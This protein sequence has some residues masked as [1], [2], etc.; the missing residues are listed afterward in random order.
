M[1]RK[2]SPLKLDFE[3]REGQDHPTLALEPRWVTV[4]AS[5]LSLIC[6]RRFVRVY[7]ISIM[8]KASSHFISVRKSLTLELSFGWKRSKF[9]RQKEIPSLTFRPSSWTWSSSDTAL[10]IQRSTSLFFS[11]P[12]SP[13][14]A[15]LGHLCL[16]SW[17]TPFPYSLPEHPSSL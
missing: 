11:F 6:E 5:N 8:E 15:L 1:W 14:P 16:P 7:P 4:V 13:V 17:L 10:C 9:T 2:I 12:V 3:V